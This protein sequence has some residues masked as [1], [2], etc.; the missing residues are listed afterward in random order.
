[1]SVNLLTDSRAQ[2][3]IQD[4]RIFNF[5]QKTKYLFKL[6]ILVKIC[7]LFSIDFGVL[8]L[9]YR[10]ILVFFSPLSLSKNTKAWLRSMPPMLLKIHDENKYQKCWCACS[11]K[12]LYIYISVCSVFILS[13]SFSRSRQESK[14]KI[15]WRGKWETIYLLV[16]NLWV[17]SSM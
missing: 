6:G 11:T 4:K 17:H 2:T 1:M 7:G 3:D 16:L 5:S 9:I 12:W 13:L 10:Y 15:L 14:F 8:C